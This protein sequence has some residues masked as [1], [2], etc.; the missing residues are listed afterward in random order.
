MQ[1]NALAA[2]RAPPDPDLHAAVWHVGKSRALLGEQ[3]SGGRNTVNIHSL[4][5]N[6]GSVYTCDGGFVVVINQADGT[7][8]ETAALCVGAAADDDTGIWV[9]HGA[10]LSRTVM[11]PAH[12][13]QRVTSTSKVRR[14]RVAQSARESGA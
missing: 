1:K 4:G 10:D 11:R 14:K 8:N 5:S 9:Q 6:A 12:P 2:R 13:V 3:F 7:F